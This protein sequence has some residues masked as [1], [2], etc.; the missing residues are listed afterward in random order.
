MQNDPARPLVNR[1][2]SGTYT[3]GSILK[4]LVSLGFLNSG[5]DPQ[6]LCFCSGMNE[7]GNATIRCAAY[8]RGGHGDVD[9][10]SALRWSCNSYM[11]ENILKV[12]K[13]PVREVLQRAGIGEGS[14]IEL[15]EATGIFPND[16]AKLKSFHRRWTSYDTALLSIGQGLITITPL[17][18]AMYTAAIANGGKLLRP[19]IIKN[20]VDPFGNTLF[21]R[22]V[23]VRNQLCE[24]D[25][26]LAVIREGMFEV[27]NSD[28]GSGR[29]AAVPGVDIY[30][31]TGSAE[32]GVRPNIKINAWFIAFTEYEG[33]KYALAVIQENARSGG[34]SCAPLAAGFFRR[35]LLQNSN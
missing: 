11:I 35:Y 1:A 22:E 6:E 19:H 34:T 30:G 7:V 4:P 20:V 27:V 14:G 29:Q 16:E 21:T 12:G 15:P 2:F 3:P 18:A 23:V 8:R 10:V 5:I 9:M 17:Q 31:K 26:H 32:V 28:T 25:D 33:K 24:N 13:T